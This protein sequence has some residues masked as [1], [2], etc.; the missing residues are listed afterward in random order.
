MDL[1]QPYLSMTA[2]QY[3]QLAR[4]ALSLDSVLENQ[5]ILAIQALVSVPFVCADIHGVLLSYSFCQVLMCHFMFL[6]FRDSPRWALMGLVVKLAQSVSSPLMCQPFTSSSPQ[7][8]S[9]GY[10]RV[11]R[12]S[13]IRHVSPCPIDRDS[14][15]WNLSKE[16]TFKRRSL[17]WE[18]YTYDSWQV[19]R[20]PL[21]TFHDVTIQ[22]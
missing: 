19:C 7:R 10:V 16:E 20:M 18:V 1:D 22:F 6:S 3:Y 12:G 17:L 4:A 9:S 5:S 11:L 8:C 15:N 13:Y 14:G 21:A 2:T